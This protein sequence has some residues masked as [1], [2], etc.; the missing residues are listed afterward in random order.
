MWC[1]KWGKRVSGFITDPHGWFTIQPTTS[2]AIV[3]NDVPPALA[4]Q[5][6]RDR[7]Y[8]IIYI[9]WYIITYICLRVAVIHI[10][11]SHV[12]PLSTARHVKC[13]SDCIYGS[14]PTGIRNAEACLVRPC[15]DICHIQWCIWIYVC[16]GHDW[17][18]IC[19]TY[20]RGWTCPTLLIQR[21]VTSVIPLAYTVR[22]GHLT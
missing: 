6:R 13:I 9:L 11:L 3:H 2:L 18:H 16:K 8:I 17:A 21:P 1:M 15:V 7:E 10:C 14:M 22:A 4:R 12:W 19:L 20:L 5:V